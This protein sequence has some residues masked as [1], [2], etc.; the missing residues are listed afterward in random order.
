VVF[1]FFVKQL[2]N[3][4]TPWVRGLSKALDHYAPDLAQWLLTPLFQ[5]V[6]AVILTLLALYILG[7]ATTRVIGVRLIALFDKIMDKIPF[8]QVVY[9]AIKK[10][11][12]V[13]QKEPEGIQRV[14]LIEFPSPS[15]KT[16]G[17]VTRILRDETTGKELAAVYVPTT[18]NPTSGYIEIVP[19]ENLVSTDW[20]ID[21]AMSFIV[22]GGAVAPDKVIYF[23]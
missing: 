23:K 21:Q 14:V 4:G 22:S 19:V 17:F 5:S 6:M 13:L 11:L 12:A 2:S 7:W 15:M 1:E 9:G 20:T 8:V 3:L 10:L 16:V 18:P